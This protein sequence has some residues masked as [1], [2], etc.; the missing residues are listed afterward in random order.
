MLSVFQYFVNELINLKSV[1]T[2]QT[3]YF[4][5]QIT[6][7]VKN[8]FTFDSGNNSVYAVI[9]NFIYLKSRRLTEHIL[10]FGFWLLDFIMFVLLSS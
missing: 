6:D 3:I 1:Y 4:K 9:T 8:Q 7:Y 10:A 2:C 5:S